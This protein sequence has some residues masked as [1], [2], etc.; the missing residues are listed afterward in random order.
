MTEITQKPI[1]MTGA[2]LTKPHAQFREGANNAIPFG[3]NSG[4][5]VS[6]EGAMWRKGHIVVN[7]GIGGSTVENY[8][9]AIFGYADTIEGLNSQI[10]RAKVV[11]F[12]ELTQ[13]YN[14]DY[15]IVVWGNEHMHSLVQGNPSSIADINAAID[16]Y[17]AMGNHLLSLGITPIFTKYPDFGVMDLSG[18][19]NFGATWVIDEPT[20][21]TLQNL[22]ET[23]LVAE[24]P[25]CIMVNAWKN[26]TNLGDGVHP[27]E[28]SMMRAARKITNAIEDFED[29]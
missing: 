26:Y 17:V 9:T 29:C 12:N 10:E 6:L 2:S 22:Y 3:T 25:G 18:F 28:K 24:V 5:Y 14:A 11:V 1:L 16:I 21:D 7:M 27:D 15:A 13:E 23:R 19:L 20:W 8:D 4:S